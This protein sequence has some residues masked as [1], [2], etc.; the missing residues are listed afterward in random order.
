MFTE[1][2]QRKKKTKKK[3]NME[4]IGTK[5]CL[6]KINKT[7]NMEKIIAKQE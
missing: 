4:E 5:T 2:F 1:I 3:E 6:K 7:K